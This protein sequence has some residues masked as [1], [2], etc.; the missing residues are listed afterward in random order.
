MRYDDVAAEIAFEVNGATWTD[1]R[2]PRQ[3]REALASLIYQA[4]QRANLDGKL[5]ARCEAPLPPV[6]LLEP[7]EQNGTAA[8]TPAFQGH[9]GTVKGSV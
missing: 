9:P 5:E 2:E 1:R 3:Q 8:P 4:M 7:P 6:K